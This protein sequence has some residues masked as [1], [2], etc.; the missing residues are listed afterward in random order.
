MQTQN[1]DNLSTGAGS[2]GGSPTMRDAADK[3]TDKIEKAAQSAHDTV[4]RVHRRA[5][6]LTDRATSEGDRMYQAACSWVSEHPLQ[7]VAGAL[8]VGYL[9]GR[10]R[11]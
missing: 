3:T 5:V 10:I 4:D 1:Y 8:F 7:A 2:A 9:Y 11:G 6:D